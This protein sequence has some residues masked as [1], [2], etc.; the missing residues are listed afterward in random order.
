MHLYTVECSNSVLVLK[1]MLTGPLYLE[2]THVLNISYLWNLFYDNLLIVIIGEVNTF[3]VRCTFQQG[4]QIE[5]VQL[6]LTQKSVYHSFHCHN[7]LEMS[8][9]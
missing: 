4:N 5:I 1:E 2:L 7:F 6:F 3:V 9:C 8:F